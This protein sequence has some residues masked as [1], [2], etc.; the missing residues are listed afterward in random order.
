MP[1]VVHDRIPEK[2]TGSDFVKT[3]TTITG[4]WSFYWEPD[5]VL[6]KDKSSKKPKWCITTKAEMEYMYYHASDR[7]CYAKQKWYNSKQEII[8][9]NQEFLMH[10]MQLSARARTLMQQLKN[11]ETATDAPLKRR[12]SSFNSYI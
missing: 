8:D 9:E 11:K 4:C 10:K 5:I 7:S 1:A 6:F 12:V 2:I 3:F